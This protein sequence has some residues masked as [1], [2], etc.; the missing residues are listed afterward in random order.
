[1]T[2]TRDTTDDG[3]EIVHIS[4]TDFRT[5]PRSVRMLLLA[6]SKPG[7]SAQSGLIVLEVRTYR[8]PEIDSE[9]RAANR[10]GSILRRGKLKKTVHY[11]N[12]Y[13]CP[14]EGAAWSRVGCTSAGKER[15]PVCHRKVKPIAVEKYMVLESTAVV[16]S[17]FSKLRAKL[18]DVMIQRFARMEKVNGANRRT[19]PK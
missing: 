1:M 6:Y 11:L 2:A 14:K 5:L 8:W 13:E 10:I 18:R 12:D 7:A 17:F 15:C 4:E 3:V 19:K 9:V 16:Q